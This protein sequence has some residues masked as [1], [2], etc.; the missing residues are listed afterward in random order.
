[1][2]TPAWAAIPDA[3]V[4]P[5]APLSSDLLTRIRNQAAAMLQYDPTSTGLPAFSLPASGIQ[6]ADTTLMFAKTSG[7]SST[8]DTAEALVAHLAEALN[9]NHIVNG[10]GDPLTGCPGSVSFFGGTGVANMG[11]LH[12][13]DINVIYASGSPS[14]LRIFMDVPQ[15]GANGGSPTTIHS[16]TSP[17]DLPLDNAFHD[18]VTVEENSADPYRVALQGRARATS[19]DIYLTIRAMATRAAFVTLV[20]FSIVRKTLVARA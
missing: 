3:D 10:V 13:L 5:E 7:P 4:A 6:V 12:I 16:A 17:V 8:V 2:T 14:A 1:M 19:T 9:D 15:A 18:M 20:N 11:I